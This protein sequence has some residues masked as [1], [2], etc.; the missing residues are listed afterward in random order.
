MRTRI[1]YMFIF[2]VNTNNENRIEGLGA[3]REYYTTEPIT[4]QILYFY[5]MPKFQLLQLLLF[6]EILS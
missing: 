1:H 2:I 4:I 6:Y 3:A 5:E